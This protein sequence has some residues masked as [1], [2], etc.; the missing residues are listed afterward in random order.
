MGLCQR[1]RRREIELELIVVGR[2]IARGQRRQA[3]VMFGEGKHRGEAGAPG[4]VVSRLGPGADYHHWHPD[5]PAG[6]GRA[7]V[8]EATT[9]IVGDEDGGATPLGAVLDRVHD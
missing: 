9:V 5:A 1:W 8:I 7:V 6:P 4:I 2:S 3:K